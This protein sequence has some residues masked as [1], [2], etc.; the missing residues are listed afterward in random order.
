MKRPLFA[1]E[2]N[3]KLLVGKVVTKYAIP[4][5]S[6]D[7]C[8]IL[9]GIVIFLEIADEIS[10]LFFFFRRRK[11]LFSVQSLILH[12]MMYLLTSLD[13]VSLGSVLGCQNFS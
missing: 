10:V 5:A 9:S 2:E 7:A 6:L 11:H 1:D 8:T 3:A 4:S 13:S 12:C